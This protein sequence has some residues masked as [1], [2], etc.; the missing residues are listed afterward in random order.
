MPTRGMYD[1]WNSGSDVNS[2]CCYGLVYLLD[3]WKCLRSLIEVHLHLHR[4]GTLAGSLE[5]V[6]VPPKYQ[7][8]QPINRDLGCRKG[9]ISINAHHTKGTRSCG[10]SNRSALAH[11]LSG[12]LMTKTQERGS[13]SSAVAGAGIGLPLHI[14]SPEAS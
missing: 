1:T 8:P 2:S 12:S 6:D 7:G 4:W 10:Y 9:N 3:S 5:G 11:S 13:A 14:H